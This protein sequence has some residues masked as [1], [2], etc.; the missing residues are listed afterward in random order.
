MTLAP[1]LDVVLTI[2]VLC[3]LAAVGCWSG[4]LW[5]VGATCRTAAR[6]AGIGE[7][8]VDAHARDAEALWR[9]AQLSAAERAA[10][11]QLV[12]AYHSPAYSRESEV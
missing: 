1:P 3:V 12:E 9:P 2:G 5:L 7:D 11:D 4:L 8:P 6:I 10:W